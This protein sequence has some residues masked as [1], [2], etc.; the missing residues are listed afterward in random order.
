MS[1]YLLPYEEL[2]AEAVASA[3]PVPEFLRR[4]L[5]NLW[6]DAY[7]EMTPRQT[8]VVTFAH[9]TF[10]YVYDDLASLEAAGV[11]KADSVTE[12]RLVGAVGTSQSNPKR[13]DD[14]RLRGWVGATGT[15]FGSA[16][17]KGHFIAHSIG[18][19]VD[20]LEANVFLQLRTVNRNGYREMERYC[21]ANPGVLCFSR[22]IYC[23]PSARPS[24]VEFGVVKPTGELW[25]QLF[26]N[27]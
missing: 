19:A 15:T 16:W 12:S 4:E 13:R 7:L 9:G 24:Q 21:A 25:V 22:P 27:R 1:D 14:S 8:N 3:M 5:P 18:G 10:D 6:Y 26:Q 17:D 23:D 2:L 11:A 20:G